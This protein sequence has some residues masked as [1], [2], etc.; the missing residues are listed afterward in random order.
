M[1]DKLVDLLTTWLN[2]FRF[3][4]VVEPFEAGIVTR[5]GKF[6]REIGPGLHWLIPFGVDNAFTEFMTSRAATL[7]E[8]SIT[9]ADG[10]S[11]GLQAVVTYKIHNARKA[12]LEVHDVVD[13]VLD[14]TQGIIGT[15][16]SSMTWVDI[17]TSNTTEVLTAVCRQRAFKLG[18]EIQAVQLASLGLAKTIRL[19]QNGNPSTLH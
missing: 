11:I 17:H 9:T 16:L 1:L 5:L 18:V 2:L 4:I 13:C 3:W 10:K 7:G 19:M 15:T 6:N 12:L 8:Q 14:A